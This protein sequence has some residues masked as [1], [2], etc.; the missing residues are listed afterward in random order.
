M[1]IQNE[2][3]KFDEKSGIQ[4][5]NTPPSSWCVDPNFL[6]ADLN[7]LKK[8]WQ[9]VASTDQLE[10]VGAYVTGDFCDEPYFII[11]TDEGTLK[12]FY[13]VCK[14]H[15][16]QLLNGEGC[17]KEIV[18]PYHAWT[19]D[20][21]GA[22][23][24]APQIAG[25]KSFDRQSLSLQEIPLKIWNKFVLL[26]FS[27]SSAELDPQ[28]E[29]LNK[30]L[31]ENGT[32]KLR[33]RERRVYEIKCNWKVYIDN[34]LD[35]GYHVGHLHK[36]L[37]GQLNMDNYTIK[38]FKTWTLQSCEGSLTPQETDSLDFKERIG[39]GALYAWMHPNF[40]INQYGDIMDT[41]WVVPVGHDKC[42]TI[43]DYY[44]REDADEAFASASINAS[45]QV[46][47]ED[48]AIC[49]SV[50]KGMKS[51]GYLSGRYAPTLETGEYLFH[52]LMKKDYL[53]E[54]KTGS[55]QG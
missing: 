53:D 24:K 37:A 10:T 9:F 54:L 48:V 26:N 21:D 43:F 1:S 23:K 49:E 4:F 46:Q 55:T 6:E 32:D 13:N 33:F 38:N 3:M 28:L 47:F 50:Q 31:K 2:V 52:C 20:L 15:A 29:L 25:I 16:A 8:H 14:H 5:S 22:L 34:Y 11:R 36:G 39:K 41:N 45:E 7:I 35:G 12:A 44:F 51:R 30:M 42:L 18:C 40:M 17:A 19:Y 27:G